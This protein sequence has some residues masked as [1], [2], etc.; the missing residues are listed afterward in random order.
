MSH[1]PLE[2]PRLI[3]LLVLFATASRLDAGY[4]PPPLY[5]LLGASDLVA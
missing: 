2:I 4:S 1:P 3:A 5:D